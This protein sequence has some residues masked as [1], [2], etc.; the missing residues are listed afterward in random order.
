[1]AAGGRTRFNSTVG[2][3]LEAAASGR[4]SCRGCGTKLPKGE[5]RFGECV[6]N[7][8]GDGEATYWFHPWCAAL[9]R[10]E[11][12]LQ[13]EAEVVALT[14]G[15][16]MLQTA[17]EGIE[18]RRLPRL[19]RVE[20]APSGRARCR[21]CRELI[22]K[23]ALRFSL[24]MF[25]DGRMNPI[26]F[27]HVSCAAAYFDTISLLPRLQRLQPDLDADTLKACRAQLDAASDARGPG[28]AKVLDASSE[29]ERKKA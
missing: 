1:M 21:S 26:G 18:Y 25:E 3:R 4:S 12:L 20:S 2:H 17:Q 27:I 23:G 13:L 22:E 10:P 28:P 11:P 8:F 14:E 9:M 5:L 19:M 24:A 16:A 6:D 15:A 29:E 7:P